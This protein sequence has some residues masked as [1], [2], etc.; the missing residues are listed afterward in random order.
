MCK[1]RVIYRY[2]HR[3]SIGVYFSPRTNWVIPKALPYFIVPRPPTES[4][5]K[6]AIVETAD[7]ASIQAG[8]GGGVISLRAKKYRPIDTQLK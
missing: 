5:P 4:E 3:V 6:G 8:C 1:F 7:T 2:S